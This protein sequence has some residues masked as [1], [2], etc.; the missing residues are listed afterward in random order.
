MKIEQNLWCLAVLGLTV[1]QI[2]LNGIEI[3]RVLVGFQ[4]QNIK[5]K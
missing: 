2:I 4:A 1:T 5:Q 3:E